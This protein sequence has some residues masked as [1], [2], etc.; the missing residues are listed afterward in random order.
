MLEETTKRKRLL[1][2]KNERKKMKEELE[3]KSDALKVGYDLALHFTHIQ[4]SIET[5]VF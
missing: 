2:E 4:F 3:Q 5:F 1:L